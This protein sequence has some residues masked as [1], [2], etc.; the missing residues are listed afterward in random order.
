MMVC[1]LLSVFCQ[2][3]DGLFAVKFFSHSYDG[4]FAVRCF[5]SVI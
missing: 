3:H 1:L 4:L 5:L 2:L